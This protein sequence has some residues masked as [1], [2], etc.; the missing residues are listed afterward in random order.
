MALT[1]EGTSMSP[2]K[3]YGISRE[4]NTPIFPI[5]ALMSTAFQE[6]SSLNP[7][8]RVTIKIRGTSAADWTEFL[9]ILVDTVDYFPTMYD[10]EEA[11]YLVTLKRPI[12]DKLNLYRS[13]PI[14]PNERFI[15]IDNMDPKNLDQSLIESHGL[16]IHSYSSMLEALRAQP[17]ALG[18]RSGAT[19]GFLLTT[20]LSLVGFG[21]NFYLN[22]SQRTVTY[23]VLR[24]LGLSTWQLYSS[25]LLEQ[26]IM[27]VSGLTLGTLLG[28]GLN[29]LTLPGLPLRLGE[30]ANIPPTIP[31]T[32]WQVVISIYLTLAVAYLISIGIGTFFLWR[33]EIHRVVR[34]GEE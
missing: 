32:D 16:V 3:L 23:G 24:A 15:S 5:P 27:V 13:I 6:R 14:Q 8:D 21:T 29:Q 4:D 18:L 1:F 12:L 34:I 17:L 19:F 25:L 9:F 11:G 7:G 10:T 28:I 31:K 26:V 22:T 2:T 20:V 33:M 30:M